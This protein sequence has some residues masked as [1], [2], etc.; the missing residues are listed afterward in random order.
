LKGLPAKKCV[1]KSCQPKSAAESIVVETLITQRTFNHELI[2]DYIPLEQQQLIKNSAATAATTAIWKLVF[3]G[4]I[5]IDHWK[6][7]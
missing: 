1:R 5:Y 3:L 4:K 7:K 2:R 6:P